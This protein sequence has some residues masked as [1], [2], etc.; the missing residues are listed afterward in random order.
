[1]RFAFVMVVIGGEPEGENFF[2]TI[3]KY[4]KYDTFD[5]ETIATQKS[6]TLRIERQNKDMKGNGRKRVSAIEPEHDCH[7]VT[8]GVFGGPPSLPS[9]RFKRRTPAKSMGEAGITRW[10]VAGARPLG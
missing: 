2:T 8:G 9:L 5:Y 4:D 6:T 10:K 3:A 7:N 1:M